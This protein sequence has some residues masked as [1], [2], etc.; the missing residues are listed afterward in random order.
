MGMPEES[1]SLSSRE[2]L[3][4]EEELIG[5][6]GSHSGAPLNNASVSQK[7]HGWSHITSRVSFREAYYE[8]RYESR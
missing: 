7:R 5:D 6:V 1:P 3:E 2:S 4:C 8:S